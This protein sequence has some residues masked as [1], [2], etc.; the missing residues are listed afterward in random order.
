M[1]RAKI[2]PRPSRF[3]DC[4]VRPFL[5]TLKRERLSSRKESREERGGYVCLR[6]F[7]SGPSLTPSL[8]KCVCVSLSFP[9]T[10]LACVSICK[11]DHSSP[12]QEQRR[13][14]E[15]ACLLCRRY[16]WYQSHCQ[17]AWKR[18]HRPSDAIARFGSRTEM[19]SHC[20]QGAHSDAQQWQKEL[21]DRMRGIESL[22]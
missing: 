18:D 4:V 20:G 3:P 12:L 14:D 16:E 21:S 19:S 10:L 6:M 5:R 17:V 2:E 15:R 13:R 1:P 8:P 9:L 22:Q 7:F 11:R